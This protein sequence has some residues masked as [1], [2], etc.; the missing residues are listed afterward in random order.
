MKD[1]TPADC[2]SWLKGLGEW[3]TK[4][5]QWVAHFEA[6]EVDGSVLVTWLEEEHTSTFTYWLEKTHHDLAHR[7]VYLAER[8]YMKAGL[9][10]L[11]EEFKKANAYRRIMEKPYIVEMRRVKRISSRKERKDLIIMQLEEGVQRE[12]TEVSL[13]AEADAMAAAEFE[14]LEADLLRTI[15]K[16][17]REISTAEQALEEARAESSDEEDAKG[18]KIK[19]VPKTEEEV[20]AQEEKEGELEDILSKESTSLAEAQ[21]DLSHAAESKVERDNFQRWLELGA[22]CREQRFGKVHAEIEIEEVEEEISV[23]PAVCLIDEEREKK[24]ELVKERNGLKATLEENYYSGELEEA[25]IELLTIEAA[26]LSGYLPQ[27]TDDMISV[28]KAMGELGDGEDAMERFKELDF[29]STELNS[30]KYRISSFLFDDV[31]ERKRKLEE[32][33][34]AKR[35]AENAAREKQEEEEKQEKAR[36]EEKRRVQMSMQESK[37]EKKGDDEDDDDEGGGF[38]VRINSDADFESDEEG[39][40]DNEEDE[41][42]EE[43]ED[44]D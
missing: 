37:E 23:M 35:K 18:K 5:R 27:L 41:E 32:A 40:E 4:N 43:E 2:I 38:R 17:E 44:E 1:W 33:G 15:S 28:Q 14:A 6:K 9:K 19:K 7:E 8:Q 36:V 29:K 21:L 10:R 34:E 26:L 3:A 24:L 20:K 16:C 12:C 13:R 42:D 11:L 22:Y 31:T 30:R 25:E 39:D